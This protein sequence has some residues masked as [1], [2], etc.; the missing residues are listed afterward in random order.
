LRVNGQ[1]DTSDKATTRDTLGFKNCVEGVYR[2]LEDPHTSPPVTLSVEGRWGSG[3]SSFMRQLQDRIISDD[4]DARI[5][6]FNA[7][8]HDKD[9]AVWAAFAVEFSKQLM[10]KR[11]SETLQDWL[12]RRVCMAWQLALSRFDWDRGW[13]DVLRTAALTVAWVAVFWAACHLGKISI[14][15]KSVPGLDW[16]AGIAVA[17]GAAAAFA[18]KFMGN[19]LRCNIR[20][21]MSKPD[22]HDKIAF[23]EKFHKDF[24]RV[25]S[26]CS[27][28]KR[29][30][31]FIDDLDRC[32]VPKAADLMQ[33]LNLMIP[34]DSSSKGSKLIYILGLDREK[35]PAGLA[36]KFKD[37]LPYIA[38]RPA[39]V[40]PDETKPAAGADERQNGIRFGYEFIEKFVQLPFLLPVPQPDNIDRF[41]S[42][43]FADRQDEDEIKRPIRPGRFIHASGCSWRAYY[44]TKGPDDTPESKPRGSDSPVPVEIVPDELPPADDKDNEPET[45]SRPLDEWQDFFNEP[46]GQRMRTFMKMVAP[47]FESNPRRLKQFACLLRLRARI[48]YETELADVEI[49]KDGKQKPGIWLG[50]LAKFVAIGLRWPLFLND[51]QDNHDLLNEMLRLD[52]DAKRDDVPDDVK[53]KCVKWS[54]ENEPELWKLI[55]WEPGSEYE[56]ERPM[57][58]FMGALP[59]KKLLS[60]LPAMPRDMA[61]EH[62]DMAD[63]DS[64]ASAGTGESSEETKPVGEDES[65]QTDAPKRKKAKSETAPK[66]RRRLGRRMILD[67]GGGVKLTLREIPDGSFL[68][69]SPAGRGE[70]YARP[71]HEVTISRP[72]FMGIYPVTQAQYEAVMGDN[73]SRFKGA[74]NPVE[75]VSWNHAVE[76]CSRLSKRA[77]K[78]VRLPSEAEWEYACRAGT[79]TA[80]WFGDDEGQLAGHAWFK[81]NS[82]G[83]THP[84]GV[85]SANRNPFGLYDMHGNVWEWCQDNW[86]DNYDGAPEDGSAWEDEP[87]GPRVLRGGAWD[88]DPRN[89]RSAYRLWCPPD[90]RH[91]SIGFR[92]LCSLPGVDLKAV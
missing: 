70:K 53:K 90:G 57:Q 72:F 77:G 19:P 83:R 33:A 30:Y 35:V 74:R 59:V 2:H 20:K 76:F 89:C 42:E 41:T 23:I 14:A 26:I 85:R 91:D 78:D 66:K 61:E 11:A 28:G 58:F 69:G 80:Y 25:A 47:A 34:D 29:V 49:D 39:P 10:E 27:G 68:M 75:N 87:V 36:V 65:P 63:G 40:S 73:P 38:S 21:Y 18:T 62:Q 54:Q 84:P 51:L 3:K 86:H 50:Q 9:E 44:Y 88:S 64:G 24:D 17:L 45:T 8:R 15:G 60:T 12:W 16:L 52:H 32:D 82:G 56:S 48:C 13:W 1:S 71:R 22:Y 55:S 31:V 43:M 79:E 81:S 92:V 6:W 46:G 5:V 4:P 7:W 37:I 67:L